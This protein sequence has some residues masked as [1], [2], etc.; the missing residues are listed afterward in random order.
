VNWIDVILISIL[1]LT[2]ILGIIKGLVKQVF[3]LLAVIIGLILALGFYSHVSWLY[4]RFVSNEVLAHFLGFLTIFLIVLC[5]G[6]VSSYGLSKFIKGPLKLLNNIL[7]GGLG[8]VKGV[9][10][11]GVVVFALL[12]F[13]I[14]KKA[15]KESALSPVCLQMTRAVISLIPK[16]LK[17]RFKEAY[18]EV[19]KR[20]KK[21]GKKI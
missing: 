2:S 6:W 18:L 16:E 11:C 21:N 1:A 14:S 4:L 3:G 8:L 17:E 12:V 10:I 9:L 20:V 19:T 7:G 15:L 5:L 13:P